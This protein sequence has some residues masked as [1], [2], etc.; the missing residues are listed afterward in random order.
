MHV[1]IPS[2]TQHPASQAAALARSREPQPDSW[3]W[4]VGRRYVG[5]VHTHTATYVPP[6]PPTLL[7]CHL[8]WY[9]TNSTWKLQWPSP[10]LLTALFGLRHLT[11][12]LKYSLIA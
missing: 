4:F 10:L 6:H 3:A 8:A 12:L 11:L 5:A 7:L 9:K 1:K 2:T